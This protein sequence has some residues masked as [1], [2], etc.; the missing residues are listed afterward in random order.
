L[1]KGQDG[2]K[3]GRDRKREKNGKEVEERDKEWQGEN[4][5]KLRTQR[6][7]YGDGCKDPLLDQGVFGHLWS[8]PLRSWND[9]N[10]R[11]KRSLHRL[12]WKREGGG[13]LEAGPI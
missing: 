13:G 11:V 1:G 6:L 10:G 5:K 2:R 12:N 9:R 7:I 3:G 4:G 8:L